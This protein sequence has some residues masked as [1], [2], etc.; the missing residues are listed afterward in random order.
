MLNKGIYYI[1]L[2]FMANIFVSCEKE[3]DSSMLW[4]KTD[5]YKDFLFYDYKP[6]KMT[7]TICFE[8]NDDANGFVK[9]VKFGIFKKDE[10]GSYI[11]VKE[12]IVLYKNGEPCLNN[13]LLVSIQDKEVELGIEFTPEAEEGIHKWF[14]KVLDNGGFDRIN[15]YATEEDS[16]PL[17]LEWKAE[18]N[19]IINPLKLGLNTFLLVLGVVLF[20]W[21]MILKPQAYPTFKLKKLYILY[22]GRQVPVKLSGVHKVVCTNRTM[23]Q[24]FFSRLFTGRIVYIKDAF[25]LP[26]DV[27]I[28]SKDRNSVKVKFTMQYTMI[29]NIVTNK[30]TGE[31]RHKEKKENVVTFRVQ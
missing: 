31:I 12:E 25:W 30:Q 4:G 17:L 20:V 1:I 26:G 6:V 14:L 28:M 15:E 27:V 23:S 18:K 2:A 11:P 21:L 10:N 7:K 16:A 19:D 24:G 3:V 8:A 5:F 29:P 13:E 22:E 9:D